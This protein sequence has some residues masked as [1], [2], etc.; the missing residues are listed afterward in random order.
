MS[1]MTA[2]IGL[3]LL[4]LIVLILICSLDRGSREDDWQDRREH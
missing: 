4:F 2:L 1:G 3:G